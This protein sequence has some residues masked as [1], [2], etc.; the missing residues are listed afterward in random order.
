M[1]IHDPTF[2]VSPFEVLHRLEK[3]FV[4]APGECGSY[5]SVGYMLLGLVL[6]H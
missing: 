1:T 4:C 2:D 5:S 3:K 6:V